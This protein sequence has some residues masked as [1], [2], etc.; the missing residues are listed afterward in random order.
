MRSSARWWLWIGLLLCAVAPASAQLPQQALQFEG[1][2]DG[3]F[4]RTSGVEAGLGISVPAGL[5]MRAGVVGGLGV[6]QNGAEGRT[7]LFARFSLD[8]FR[9]SRWAP[10]AGGGISARY[11]VDEDGGSHAYLLVFLGVEGP[12]AT[13]RTSGWV[14][15]FEVGLGGGARVAAIIRRG[16]NGRR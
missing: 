4:A 5:Y 1:R 10:Y 7:D 11:R 8:P 6:G 2:I 12:L 9:Q 16:I 15:A 3:L 14:P 13:G